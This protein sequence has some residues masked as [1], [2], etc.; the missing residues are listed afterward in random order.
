VVRIDRSTDGKRGRRSGHDLEDGG[1][2]QQPHDHLEIKASGGPD[3]RLRLE[4]RADGGTGD[5]MLSACV[6]CFA[7]WLWAETDQALPS[8]T[9]MATWSVVLRD[10]RSRIGRVRGR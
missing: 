10:V 4:G 5:L 6:L 8:L 9:L 3:G 7:A 2:L 1:A